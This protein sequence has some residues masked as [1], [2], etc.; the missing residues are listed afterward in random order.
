MHNDVDRYLHHHVRQTVWQSP[1][2][3]EQFIIELKML[4]DKDGDINETTGFERIIPLPSYDDEYYVYMLGG[5]SPD[6]FGLPPVYEE[7]V[8]LTEWT[9]TSNSVARLY[10][11]HGILVPY[12]N[13]FYYREYDGNLMFA[14]LDDGALPYKVQME[15][16]YIHFRTP[17]YLTNNS[18]I[19]QEKRQYVSS[20]RL[21][22]TGPTANFLLD[23][24]MRNQDDRR[25][26]LSF[27]NG[28]PQHVFTNTKFKDVA[29]L[30][31]DGSLYHR[32]YFRVS[33]LTF[34][35]S[36]LDKCN[37][38][39]ILTR[40]LNK[41]DVVYRDDVE[42]FLVRYRTE[43]IELTKAANPEM[44]DP[45]EVLDHTYVTDGCY[46]HRN[47]EDSLRMV[48]HQSY[49]IP[50][51]YVHAAIDHLDSTRNLDQWYLKVTYR[52]SGL[53]R[54]LMSER[55]RIQ[56][57]VQME[58]ED[59]LATMTGNE[60]SLLLWRAEELERS[61]YMYLMR[62]FNHELTTKKVIEAYGYEQLA[63][64]LANP[65][66]SI[67]RRPDRDYFALP[68]MLSE[69]ATVFEFNRYGR[70]M[71]WFKTQDCLRYL[72]SSPE[73][74]FVEAFAGHG[75]RCPTHVINPATYPYDRYINVRVYKVD[76]NSKGVF[77]GKITDVSTNPAFVNQTGD[78][79]I[80]TL[81]ESYYDLILKTDDNFLCKTIT[82]DGNTDGVYDFI[83]T[84]GQDNEIDLIPPA[85]IAVW[86]NDQALVEGIDYTVDYP[87]VVILSKER[88]N[89]TKEHPEAVVTY[90]C[91]GFCNEDMTMPGY[92]EAGYVIQEKLSVDD[93]YDLHY[94]R[95][96]R[97]VIDG[98]VYN[99]RLLKWD[100]KY[101]E[102]L[103]TGIPNGRPYSIDTHA[104]SLRGL[105]GHKEVY[106]MYEQDKKDTLEITQFLSSKIRREHQIENDVIEIQYRVYS[107]FLSAII[108]HLLQDQTRY[109]KLNYRDK[110]TIETLVSRYKY[111]LKADPAYL[112][113][114]PNRMWIH[115]E[116]YQYDERIVVHH[117]ILMILKAINKWYLN[118]R[119]DINRWFKTNRTR[120]VEQ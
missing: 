26:P 76:K 98:G 62:A 55:H 33:D 111:L 25:V 88:L 91:L 61:A 57:L 66:I 52:R 28:K 118:E 18:K 5:N 40:Y 49:G 16:L 69:K 77:T 30:Y 80:L 93:S 17:Q 2:V 56:A 42:I 115:P 97:V 39:L 31:D 64:A 96:S 1:Y 58:Y 27:L 32:E 100:R 7:W 24:L 35:Q 45:F 95:L 47:K 41:Q 15:P 14:V 101:G 38:Y 43:D 51:D 9:N 72:P 83:V 63:T 82:L 67:T 116:P 84:H 53:S 10:N 23:V 75:T 117:R 21:G 12:R 46:Y 114:D 36:I 13:I 74:I 34:Y 110:Q 59:Q 78:K 73:T 65:N 19:P 71:G 89:V 81:N 4:S 60:T 8:P 107:P 99:P 90:R 105:G 20:N 103:V 44:L 92:R 102:A 119:V 6:E 54:E 70:L 120:Q 106:E 108:H 87:R 29:E 37:K 113:Y 79:Y 11:K 48:T 94:N 22:V 109:L 50:V 3:D 104:I 85:K 86:V 112:D 68:V